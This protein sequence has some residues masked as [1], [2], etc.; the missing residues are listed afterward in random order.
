MALQATDSL[1]IVLREKTSEVEML[2]AKM[3]AVS[4]ENET[5]INRLEAQ[6]YL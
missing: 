3:Q 5:E 6:R 4:I 2:K 1:E